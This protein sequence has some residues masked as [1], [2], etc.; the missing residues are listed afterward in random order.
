M[1]TPIRG[2]FGAGDV[3]PRCGQSTDRGLEKFLGRL[4]ISDGMISNLKN[5]ME[6]VDL[7]E[8]LDTVRDY[9]RTRGKRAKRYARENPWKVAAGVAVFAVGVGLL[10]SVLK[11]E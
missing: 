5:S 3:C 9:L 10:I 4:G 1:D 2:E 11:R 7:E 6:N 8:Y